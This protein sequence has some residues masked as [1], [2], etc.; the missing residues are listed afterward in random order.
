MLD[1]ITCCRSNWSDPVTE[2]YRLPFIFIVQCSEL[3]L[4]SP[5]NLLAAGVFFAKNLTSLRT[6]SERRT[7][8][9]SDG[10]L[11]IK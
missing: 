11:I 2:R 6:C 3:I 7:P 8:S 10:G 5:Y 9:E 1:L 4:W